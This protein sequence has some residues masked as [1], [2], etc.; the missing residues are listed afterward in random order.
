MKFCTLILLF[1]STTLYAQQDFSWWNELHNWDGHSPWTQYLTMSTS[2]MGPN[3]LPVP[4]VKQGELEKELRIEILSG[5]HFA[6][7]DNTQ[8][9]Y[10]GLFVPLYEGKIALE[11]FVVPLEFFSTD[12]ATRDL[13][14][15]RTKSGKGRAGGDIYFSTQ[16]QLLQNREKWPDI[17]LELAFRTASGTRLRDARHT[18]GSGYYMDLSAGKTFDIAGER[19][20]QLR[21]FAMLGFYSYQTHDPLH[22]QNDCWMEGIGAELNM[23]IFSVSQTFSG[24]RGYLD[25]GDQPLVYKGSLIWKRRKLDA[26]VWYQWGI[27]DFPYKSIRLGIIYHLP[28]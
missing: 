12:T 25:I 18:D 11:A 9:L 27:H 26:K 8:D 7:G 24:Y 2:F 20:L 22:L 19:D 28:V 21:L 23:K 3:A 6:K 5:A 17:L 16:V 14:A 10:T 13:R 4:E 15:A 1:F